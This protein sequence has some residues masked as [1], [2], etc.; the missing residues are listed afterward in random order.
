[1]F[2]PVLGFLSELINF[3][4]EKLRETFLGGVGEKIREFLVAE[5]RSRG[6]HLDSSGNVDPVSLCVIALVCRTN[7]FSEFSD[8]QQDIRLFYQMKRL[9]AHLQQFREELTASV[10]LRVGVV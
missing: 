1:M 5:V 8:C 9:Q 6:D 7:V 3:F 4:L 10:D 2:I